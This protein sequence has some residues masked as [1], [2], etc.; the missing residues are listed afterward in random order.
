MDPVAPSHATAEALV[1]K[2]QQGVDSLEQLK[3]AADG[4]LLPQIPKDGKELKE[5][6]EVGFPRWFEVNSL[7]TLEPVQKREP[8]DQADAPPSTTLLKSIVTPETSEKVLVEMAF[9]S[10]EAN[11]STPLPANKDTVLGGGPLVEGEFD[12][13]YREEQEAYMAK[14]GLKGLSTSRWA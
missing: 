7:T 1:V 12:E 13:T 14:K 11:V 9:G 4:K 6:L 2:L 10:H 3:I 8:M 5:W